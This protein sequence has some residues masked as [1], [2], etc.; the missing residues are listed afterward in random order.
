MK[1]ILTRDVPEVGQAG[2]IKKVA[3]G[4]ARNYLIPQGLA[5]VATPAAVKEFEQRHVSE[6]RRHQRLDEQAAA[7]AER[8]A[9]LQLT[10]Q[11]KA[12]ESGRLYGSIT[13]ADIAHALE[14]EL[15]EKFDRRKNIIAEPIR[16][17]GEHTVQI[18]L[19]SDIVADLSL[20]VSPEGEGSAADLGISPEADVSTDDQGPE[21]QSATGDD[22]ESPD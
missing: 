22:S 19:T 2:E 1:V 15:G 10:F 17:V 14:Q 6:T 16:Q 20:L 11:A 21:L 7:L 18:R 4:Y 5:V 13:A 9:G 12:G 3:P 8:I